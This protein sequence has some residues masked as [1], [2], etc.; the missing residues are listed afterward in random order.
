[1]WLFN[2]NF[3]II[4]KFNHIQDFMSIISIQ[5]LR[6]KRRLK[7][8]VILVHEYYRL[9]SPSKTFERCRL[10]INFMIKNPNF[11]RDSS[12]IKRDNGN[13]CIFDP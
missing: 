3:I 1:M 12:F 2:N 4:N 8:S 13:G 6:S 11:P 9:K 10:K 5:D 7:S